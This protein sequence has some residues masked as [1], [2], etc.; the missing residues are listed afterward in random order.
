ML[1]APRHWK[2]DA[3]IVRE[4]AHRSP[5][6]V[7]IRSK[8][9]IGQA[10]AQCTRGGK[11]A[12][13]AWQ[14][15]AGWS[16]ARAGR[17]AGR[18]AATLAPKRLVLPPHPDLAGGRAGVAHVLDVIDLVTALERVEIARQRAVAVEV[19]EAA[20]LGHEKAEILLGR[21]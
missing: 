18:R 16:A 5:D 17:S 12:N 3:P 7:R 11:A 21:E 4:T 19:Q 1:R 13:G 10:L 20:F 6:A 2:P 14:A 15:S 9:G 8:A